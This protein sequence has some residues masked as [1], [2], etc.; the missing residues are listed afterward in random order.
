MYTIT[1]IV[2]LSN[3]HKR[4][5]R[6]KKMKM[7]QFNRLTNHNRLVCNVY[8]GKQV[9][10]SSRWNGHSNSETTLVDKFLLNR[11]L[12]GFKVVCYCVNPFK[13]RKFFEKLGSVVINQV[14]HVMKKPMNVEAGFDLNTQNKS[15][16]SEEFWCV[17]CGIFSYAVKSP[18]RI[19]YTTDTHLVKAR[20][21]I[22]ESTTVFMQFYQKVKNASS[23]EEIAAICESIGPLEK[24]EGVSCV[25][26]KRSKKHENN[27]GH[28]DEDETTG[29]ESEESEEK[30]ESNDVPQQASK[31]SKKEISDKDSP[32]KVSLLLISFVVLRL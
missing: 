30:S 7:T 10:K 23:I 2:L 16:D 9:S 29:D 13:K 32:V 4:M 22:P 28:D 12:K 5:K 6:T 17:Q 14:R 21:S 11:R 3:H 1:T 24:I 8:V 31:R 27:G 26:T 18:T 25:R 19:Q 15:F 20:S